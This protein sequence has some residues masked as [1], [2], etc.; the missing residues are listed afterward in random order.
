ASDGRRRHAIWKR[1]GQRTVIPFSVVVARCPTT[2]A[3]DGVTGGDRDAG[4]VRVAWERQ[5]APANRQPTGG[6]RADE[7][8][9]EYETG[10]RQQIVPVVGDER[11]VVDLPAD[12]CA[13]TRRKE[14]VA[15]MS[16]LVVVAAPL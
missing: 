2:G 13:R 1:D 14:H 15:E 5:L 7:P 12:Q 9:P 8:A 3:A 6:D 4:D 11:D 16:R 10:A